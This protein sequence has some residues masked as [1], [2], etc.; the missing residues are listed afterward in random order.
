[1]WAGIVVAVG[2]G[3]RSPPSR[4]RTLVAG[5][6]AGLIAG[7]VAA[8]TIDLFTLGGSR[9]FWLLGAVGLVASERIAPPLSLEGRRRLVA[10]GLLAAGAGL[11]IGVIA[12]AVFPRTSARE[13]V[14]TTWPAKAEASDQG[15]G[16]HIG[17]VYVNSVCEHSAALDGASTDAQ[18][19]CRGVRDSSGAGLLRISARNDRALEQAATNEQSIGKVLSGF[20]LLSAGPVIDALPT[21]VRTA[22]IWLAALFAFVAWIPRLRP[23][24]RTPA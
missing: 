16:F 19:D 6:F 3:L 7:L 11:V 8:G 17:A 4:E 1:M 15:S 24:P 9:V 5:C 23:R 18:I 14:F 20:E 10:P 13:F 22:P 2:W 12:I 21:P